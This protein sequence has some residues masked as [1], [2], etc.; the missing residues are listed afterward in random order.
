[1]GRIVVRPECL[2]RVETLEPAGPVG[3]YGGLPLPK[4]NARKRGTIRCDHERHAHAQ[5]VR[6][7]YQDDGIT[8]LV[9]LEPDT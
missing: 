3:N 5:G 7:T 4:W 9:Y 2:T 6:G 1:M 8:A